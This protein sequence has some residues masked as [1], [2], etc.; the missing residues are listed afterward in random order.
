MWLCVVLECIPV[1]P[2]TIAHPHKTKN[3]RVRSFIS[4]PNGERHS[5]AMPHSIIKTKLLKTKLD[6][7]YNYDHRTDTPAVAPCLFPSLYLSLLVCI[8]HSL[9]LV[10]LGL[11]FT[12][13]TQ[14]LFSFL[15]RHHLWDFYES[16]RMCLCV[17]FASFD[18][19]FRLRCICV[20][21]S[22][23]C[24]F[25]LYSIQSLIYYFWFFFIAFAAGVK[26]SEKKAARHAL[27]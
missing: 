4:Q 7:L 22:S 1:P 17:F 23:V 25:L 12:H 13:W 2:V 14:L 16:E 27:V 18:L 20:S 6:M 3:M 10:T 21:F 26:E 19:F 9:S 5:E 11:Y 15:F 24:L 8:S